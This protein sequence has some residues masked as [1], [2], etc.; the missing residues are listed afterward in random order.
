MLFGNRINNIRSDCG[1]PRAT[2]SAQKSRIETFIP[3]NSPSKTAFNNGDQTMFND[4]NFN[5]VRTEI[6]RLNYPG[7][8]CTS[9]TKNCS[10]MASKLLKSD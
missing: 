6:Y 7:H 8:L 4:R 5:I 10:V 2:G 1:L 9:T 3:A